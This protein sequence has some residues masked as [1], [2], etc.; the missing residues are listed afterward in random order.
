MQFHLMNKFAM[1]LQIKSHFPL[2]FE[3]NLNLILALPSI[4]F[5]IL[6]VISLLV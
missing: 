2:A 4:V 5:L 3:W 1:T 6:L